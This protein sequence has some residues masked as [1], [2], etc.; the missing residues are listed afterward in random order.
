M[1]KKAER[2][3]D[4]VARHFLHET[5]GENANGQ[6]V[7]KKQSSFLPLPTEE[8]KKNHRERAKI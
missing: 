7:K 6:K 4:K 8:L 5:S 3:K 2:Q 1:K